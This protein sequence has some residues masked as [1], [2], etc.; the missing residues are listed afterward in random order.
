MIEYKLFIK[1]SKEKKE[2]PSLHTGHTIQLASM[3]FLCSF[4]CKSKKSKKKKRR[5]VVRHPFLPF[6][7][8]TVSLSYNDR[9]SI[10]V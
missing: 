4:V 3:F 10:E 6:L 9:L 1:E 5:V 7:H 2:D 8:L